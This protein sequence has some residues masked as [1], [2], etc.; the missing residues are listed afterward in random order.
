MGFERFRVELEGAPGGFAS[1]L[2][3]AFADQADREGAEGV[4]AFFGSSFR[5]SSANFFASAKR[6]L[7]RR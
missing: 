6:L 5:A 4:S 2:L 7:F 3:L 1:L